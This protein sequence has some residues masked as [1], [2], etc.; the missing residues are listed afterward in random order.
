MLRGESTARAV[1][2][3][4]TAGP[5]RPGRVLPPPVER[6]VLSR[7][8]PD[9][10]SAVLRAGEA[11]VAVPHVAE[12]RSGARIG[13]R[14]GDVPAPRLEDVYAD[15]LHRLR[16]QARTDGW[17]AGHAEGL[18]VAAD[19]VARVEAEAAQRLA[20]TQQRW[21][22]RIASTVAALTAAC[23]QVDAAPPLG[24]ETFDQLVLG[25]TLTLV[26][27]VFAREL[28]VSAQPGTD[29]LHRALALSPEDGPTVVRL[30]P[31]DL[32]RIPAP[33]LAGLPASVRLLADPRVEP[34]GAVAE[35][36]VCRVDAQLG[37]ALAR[38]TEVLRS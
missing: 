37:P 19:A 9:G 38:V 20:Q 24:G 22:A 35:T 5:G 6:P 7:T 11:S 4:R 28:A 33:V 15:E 16:E 2:W 26:E 10:S 23:A 1:A 18:A 27:E 17:A 3:D 13:R 14:A 31:D 34:A 21:E 8:D 25:A 29:A 32:Q 12:R 36:G 30:N